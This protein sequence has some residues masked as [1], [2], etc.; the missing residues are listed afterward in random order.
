MKRR[1]FLVGLGALPLA[2]CGTPPILYA[3]DSEVQRFATVQPG[4]KFIKLVTMV[5]NESGFGAHSFLV[6]NASQAVIFDP[7]GGVN[8]EIIPEQNDVLYGISR[9]VEEMFISSHARTTFHARVQRKE[10]SPEVA[11]L[12]FRLARE[13]GGV[14]YGQCANATSGIISR[15]P[16]MSPVRQALYP[17]TVADLF[18][19]VPGVTEQRIFE[20]DDDDK[21]LALRGLDELVR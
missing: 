4:P 17:N 6:I 13:W 11:E 7:A 19:Q 2:A 5:N 14:Q 20:N 18:A 9:Q 16:G 21:E 8:H 1:A 12:A 3:P 10:L 15:L